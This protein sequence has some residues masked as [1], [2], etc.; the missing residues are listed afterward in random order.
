MTSET[1]YVEGKTDTPMIEAPGPTAALVL[2]FL[3]WRVDTAG[4]SVR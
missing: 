3:R 2:D 4:V 1:A